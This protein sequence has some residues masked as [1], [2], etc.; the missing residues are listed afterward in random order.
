MFNQK[1]IDEFNNVKARKL[2]KSFYANGDVL[3]ISKDLL[4][5]FLMTNING[6]VTG[7]VIVETEAYNGRCDKACHAFPEK[8]T[9]RTEIMY[10]SGGRAYVYLCYGIHY[11]FNITT[12]VTDKAD[13]VLVRA[14]EPVEGIDVMLKRR[15]LQVVKP[16]L[17]AGP[18]VLTQA[19]GINKRHYGADLSGSEVWIEDRNILIME[20]DVVAC[21]RIGVAYAEEDALLPWRFYIKGNKFVSKI[22]SA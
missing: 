14:I 10:N 15:N 18:G 8:R 4:G 20:E 11:L 2:E 12:N 5:K 16:Q 17:T 1:K 13:A 21:P 22:K 19:L 9:K 7:G 3:E 6:V